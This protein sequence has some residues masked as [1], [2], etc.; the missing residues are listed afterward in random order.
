VAHSGHGCQTAKQLYFI[1]SLQETRHTI[2]PLCS[3]SGKTRSNDGF[4]NPAVAALDLVL[5][6]STYEVE[7]EVELDDASALSLGNLI[8]RWQ[9]CV[10]VNLIVA[11]LTQKHKIHSL[12]IKVKVS[13]FSYNCIMWY[14]KKV[15]KWLKNLDTVLLSFC[16]YLLSWA[17]RGLT[18]HS[19]HN[20]SFRGQIFQAINYTGTDNK[21]ITN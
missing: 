9:Q 13:H 14:T 6:V 5:H 7:R 16:L 8:S 1:H 19:T 11:V 17:E 21:K 15:T 10:A 2:T 18:S 12:F 20:R 3:R 4:R